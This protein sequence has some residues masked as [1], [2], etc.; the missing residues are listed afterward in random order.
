LSRHSHA[1]SNVTGGEVAAAVLQTN[2][3]ATI[4]NVLAR[5]IRAFYQKRWLFETPP[6]DCDAKS[7]GGILG[8][9][10]VGL[11]VPLIGLY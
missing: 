3:T 9:P 5:V 10:S 4:V 7:S 8:K 2:A 1:D 6:C 11:D